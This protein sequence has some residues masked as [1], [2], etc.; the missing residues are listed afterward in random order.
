MG[1]PPFGPSNQSGARSR[2]GHL[3]RWLLPQKKSNEQKPPPRGAAIMGDQG[4]NSPTVS[5]KKRTGESSPGVGGGSNPRGA[6]RSMGRG[7]GTLRSP[8][9]QGGGC[10]QEKR[11][12][13]NRESNLGSNPRKSGG[14]RKWV[15]R[16]RPGALSIREISNTREIKQKTNPYVKHFF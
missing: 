5:K 2:G 14:D 1:G 4:D 11:R 13:N 6:Q 8:R 12:G 3:I 15:G 16:T 10:T 7:A 9:D